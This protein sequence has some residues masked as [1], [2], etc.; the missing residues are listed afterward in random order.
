MDRID[1]KLLA[2]AEVAYSDTYLF[3]DGAWAAGS[4]GRTLPVMNP[5]TGL[6]MATVARAEIADLDRALAAAEDR[7]SVV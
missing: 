4:G 1:P 5:A 2:S 3:I 6:Q 7:K